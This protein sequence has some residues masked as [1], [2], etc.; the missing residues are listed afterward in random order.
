MF[1]FKA[2][3]INELKAEYKR[4]DKESGDD[5]FFTKKELRHLPNILM[6]GEPA[7]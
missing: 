1:D 6:D 4:I 7:R 3:S 5:Q 2:A